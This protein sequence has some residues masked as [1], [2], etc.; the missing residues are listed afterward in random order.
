MGPL[1]FVTLVLLGVTWGILGVSFWYPLGI[2]GFLTNYL[3][4][5]M[6]NFLTN[7]LPETSPFLSAQMAVLSTFFQMF[8]VLGMYSFGGWKVPSDLGVE[9][10][11]YE[12]WGW[13]LCG[14]MNPTNPTQL[15]PNLDPGD[16]T[17]PD[18]TWIWTLGAQPDPKSGSIGFNKYIIRLNP[19]L[20]PIWGKPDPIGPV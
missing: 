8:I 1:T 11:G 13:N 12:Y 18:S 19:N 5:F 15:S 17:R 9:K 16:P 7:F 20:N 3:K 10:S 2:L 14:Q 4:N 6:T